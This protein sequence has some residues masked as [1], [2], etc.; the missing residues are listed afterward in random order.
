MPNIPLPPPQPLPP[1]PLPSRSF[2]SGGLIGS[3]LTDAGP[4]SREVGDDAIAW[5]VRFLDLRASE[6]RG[7]RPSCHPVRVTAVS[8]LLRFLEEKGDNGLTTAEREEG[9]REREG[10]R[11][12]ERER[13]WVCVGVWG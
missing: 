5:Q 6:L 2:R 13:E 4:A 12:R 3:I 1:P 8:R 10:E 11:R 7:E 9:G